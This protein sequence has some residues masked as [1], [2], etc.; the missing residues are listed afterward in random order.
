[1]AAPRIT[2]EDVIRTANELV[3]AGEHPSVST[4]REALG[5]RGSFT[6][7]TKHL[8]EWRLQQEEV[9]TKADLPERVEAAYRKAAAF[10]WSEARRQAGEE[11]ALI[12]E[13]MEQ[14]EARLVKDATESAAEVGRLEK[15]VQDLEQKAAKTDKALNEL[16]EREAQA[17]EEAS[18]HKAE[19]EASGQRVKACEG[20]RDSLKAENKQLLVQ[21][22]KLEAEIQ[23]IKSGSSQ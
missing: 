16:R 14:K 10:A 3:E 2:L 18:R 1:M 22:G 8:Q 11:V 6:T 23:F 12:K 19:N 9:N 17:R 4:V 7:I 20:E 15:Q 13:Q 5:G 21:T